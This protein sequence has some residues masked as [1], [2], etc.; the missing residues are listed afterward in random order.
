MVGRQ[1][2]AAADE[3]N[4]AAAVPT[5][6]R[7]SHKKNGSEEG[8]HAGIIIAT[9]IAFKSSA[10]LVVYLALLRKQKAKYGAVYCV[11]CCFLLI[12]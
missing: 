4:F 3:G 12:T 8:G 9:H 7:R 5:C 11:I 6:C 10:P 1:T 2:F